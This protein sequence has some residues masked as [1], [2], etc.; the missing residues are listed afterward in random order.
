MRQ[1]DKKNKEIIERLEQEPVFDFLKQ[2]KKEFPDAELYL[3]GGAVRDLFLERECK[4]YDFVVRNVEAKK[5]QEF[6]GKIGVVNLVGRVFGV[7]K[8]IPEA[9]RAEFKE[10]NLEPFDIAL[11]R[12]E[13]S[14]FSGGYRDFDV[15]SDPNLP[16][17]KDLA[18][19]DFTINAMGIRIPNGN[20]YTNLIIDPFGGLKDLEKKLTRTVGEPKERFQEDYSRMLRALR[21]ACQLNFTI[22]KKTLKTIKEKINALVEKDKTD[23]IIPRETIAKEMLKTFYASPVQAFDLYDESGAFDV[24]MPEIAQ[25]KNCPQPPEFH[26]EGDVFVHTRLALQILESETYKKLA[27]D[28]RPNAQLIMA[29]LFHDIGKL[30]TIQTPEND[31]SDRV[32]FNNHHE[33]GADMAKVIIRRLKLDSQPT[34]MPLHVNEDKIIWLIKNHL[35]ILMG[36]PKEMRAATVEKYFFNQLRPGD[37][38]IRLIFCDAQATIPKNGKPEMKDFEAMMTRIAEV[39]KIARERDILP[40]PILNGDEIMEALGLKPGPQ[41][42][43]I[44]YAL[45]EEQLEGRVT[46]T[47]EALE[48]IKNLK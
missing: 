42:G 14:F 32:R 9:N 24:L 18:R 10:K 19:R 29:L 21:F 17:E 4:D 48:F 39:G 43:K 23:W 33:I 47:K 30:P 5:L 34:A 45:R 27:N 25:M 31:N 36:D 13:H 8:F 6:L 41:I 12:T 40:P 38:L 3:V 16:I 11:P 15:Q 1:T 22:E 20:E 35:L 7:F 44:I 37:E 46:D 26:T 2:I 28:E